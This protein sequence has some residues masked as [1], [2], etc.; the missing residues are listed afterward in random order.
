MTHGDDP[1]QWIVVTEDART[2]PV[3]EVLT[4]RGF[5]TGKSGS[6]KSNTMSVFAE[7]L[8]EANYNMLI[9]DT[10]GEYWGL[11]ERYDLL[12][13]GKT[14]ECDVQIDS[15]HAEKLAS[16][17]LN[18]NIPTILDVSEFTDLEEAS[19]LIHDVVEEIFQQEN[20]LRKPFLLIV[21]EIQEY[22]PQSGGK[23]ELA[24]LFLRVAKR[25]RKRGLG[26][27]GISQRPAAVDK[28]FIT[29]CDWLVWHRLTWENDLNVVERLLGEDVAREIADLADGEA[30]LMTDWDG[31]VDRVQFRRK[32]TFDAGATPGLEE[33][34]RPDLKSVG[35][36]LI[37]ELGGE[38]NLVIDPVSELEQR[39]AESPR[40]TEPPD[41]GVS[42]GVDDLDLAVED[43]ENRSV[44]TDEPEELRRMLKEERKRNDILQDEVRELKQIIENIDETQSD[45]QPSSSNN[46]QDGGRGGSM[47]DE[48]RHEGPAGIVT[49][50]G[51]L[52]TFVVMRVFRVFTMLVSPF[53]QRLESG[54]R[55]V[56]ARQ[57]SHYPIAS[58]PEP[59]RSDLVT[60][61]L[62]VG[63]LVLV[64][65]G[66]VILV[67]AA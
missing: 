55:R 42:A 23:D 4:G 40:S 33:Y 57:S 65:V 39:L 14:D 7:E 64:V 43:I 2:L 53:S 31:Q 50:L 3:A 62:F 47:F 66:V 13:V 11:K 6:G 15:S 54:S 56:R 30:Y 27:C 12:H 25:G 16:I 51:L 38:S 20:E 61:A 63:L 41:G 32:K 17:A 22:L 29:Q 49:E 28:D 1:T 21:E 9:V 35:Q 48:P 34:D 45:H 59:D 44:E 36:E 37:S 58:T 19:T 67:T 24:N 52:V 60:I 5:I 10:E 46:G 8:L 18:R 26:L